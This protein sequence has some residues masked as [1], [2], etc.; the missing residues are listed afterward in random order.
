M[1]WHVAPWRA[2]RGTLA[3]PSRASRGRAYGRVGSVRRSGAQ[4]SPWRDTGRNLNPAIP[5]PRTS[6]SGH[7]VLRATWNTSGSSDGASVQSRAGVSR[8]WRGRRNAQHRALHP[9][10]GL[11][12]G[13]YDPAQASPLPRHD[14]R[15]MVRRRHCLLHGSSH[16]MRLP[17]RVRRA[18][19]H[20]LQVC[21]GPG[22]RGPAAREADA[23]RCEAASTRCA[24]YPSGCEDARTGR[25]RAS[26]GSAVTSTG[27][28]MHTIRCALASHQVAARA[29][30][31]CAATPDARPHD[32][33]VLG[34][35]II[36][37]RRPLTARDATPRARPSHPGA[38]A[39]Q[40]EAAP[41][42]IGGEV[43]GPGVPV[44][45]SCARV[46]RPGAQVRLIEARAPP[47]RAG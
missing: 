38:R 35:P 39:S 2:R 5:G 6:E 16:P 28:V 19:H 13:V 8:Q 3:E 40:W 10:T 9:S 42:G 45:R 12:Q 21:R 17:P 30:S 1:I 32:P 24:T 18:L 47:V 29:P 20:A 34:H 44:P 46:T 36:A 33:G 22:L 23:G 41:P 31:A 11:L 15:R 4:P 26:S 43:A 14:D 37:T 25:G 7:G 27:R